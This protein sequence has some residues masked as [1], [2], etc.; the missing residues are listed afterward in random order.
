MRLAALAVVLVAS[1][2]AA[3]DP[4][5]D[6]AAERAGD[7]NLESTSRRS[8]RNF[9]AA[10]GGGLTLGFG[11]EDSVGRGGSASFRLGQ[12]ATERSVLTLEIAGVASFHKVNAEGAELKRNDD[13][14]FLVGA[15][16]WINP[17]LWVRIAVG[18]GVYKG[19]D[20]GPDLDDVT[21]VGPAGLF[22]AGFDLVR[23]RRLAFGIEMMSIGMINRD[24]LLASNAFMLDL[25]IE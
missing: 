14:N 13:T 16:R 7:A 15:Q 24:G 1:G 22:G 8:G 9:T 3:A 12:V 4:Q 19:D 23:T 2:P 25:S 6:P 20:V 18:L 17:A 11:I 21:L 10:L 5:P